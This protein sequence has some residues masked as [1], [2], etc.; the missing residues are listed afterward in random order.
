[1]PADLVIAVP[2]RGSCRVEWAS[3][4]KM[5]EPPVNY[6]WALRFIT[7]EQV[8]D[9]RNGSVLDA[10]ELGAKYLMFI[11]DDTL[12]PNQGLRRLVY[13]MEQHPDWDLLSGVYV[14]KTDPPQTLIFTEGS[15]GPAWDWKFN[16]QFPITGCGMGCCLIRMDAFDKVP[17]PWFKFVRTPEGKNSSEEGEDLYFCRKLEEAG[18]TLMADGGLLCGHINPKGE[19]FSLPADSLPLKDSTINDFTVIDASETLVAK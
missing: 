17:E 7:G 18:G 6:S 1:M 13:L 14:T 16:S 19:I 12:I 2:S 5:L 9:A 8:D 15:P 4:L 11:D 3:T 10:R